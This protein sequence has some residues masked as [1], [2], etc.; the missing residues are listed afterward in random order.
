MELLR[1]PGTK[2]ANQTSEF[3]RRTNHIQII[4]VSSIH[5]IAVFC[6]GTCC[7][8]AIQ[9]VTGPDFIKLQHRGT[10]HHVQILA[11]NKLTIEQILAVQEVPELRLALLWQALQNLMPG[12]G[13]GP[14]LAAGCCINVILHQLC[15]PVTFSLPASDCQDLSA[16]CHA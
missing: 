14:V 4:G 8:M 13:A 7:Q 10:P 6:A 12:V 3:S 16:S 2:T 15:R 5:F 9:V 11:K 1:F